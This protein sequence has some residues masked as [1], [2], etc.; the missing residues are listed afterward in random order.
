MVRCMHKLESTLPLGILHHASLTRLNYRIIVQAITLIGNIIST[1]AKYHTRGYERKLQQVFSKEL[2]ID[3][4][5]RDTTPKVATN[6]LYVCL[7]VCVCLT[8]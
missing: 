4:A 6:S 5:G 8:T 2:L 7:C 3:S 1:G